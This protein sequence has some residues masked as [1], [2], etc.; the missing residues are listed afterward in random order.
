M[1]LK[2]SKTS[3]QDSHAE[4]ISKLKEYHS[5]ILETLQAE[6]KTEVIIYPTF[7]KPIIHYMHTLFL[8]L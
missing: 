5:S 8:Q 7:Y 6:F 4:Q 2:E 1:N 3:L